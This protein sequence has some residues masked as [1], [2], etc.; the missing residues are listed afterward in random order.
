M[1]KMRKVD[2]TYK[3]GLIVIGGGITG[4]TSAVTW[5]RFH[6][7]EKE[8]VLIIEKEPKLGGFVTS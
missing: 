8:P 6:D 2:E 7:T 1:V 5:A 4:L 3:N